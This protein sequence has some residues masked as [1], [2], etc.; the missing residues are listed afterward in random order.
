VER[1]VAL[2]IAT[3][4]DRDARASQRGPPTA[5][6]VRQAREAAG[7]RRDNRAP[8][9]ASKGVGRAERSSLGQPAH[10]PQMPPPPSEGNGK[11]AACPGALSP[12]KA[13]SGDG[14]VSP[15]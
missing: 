1:A 5:A 4:H 11:G 6:R 9:K 2:R 3:V 13:R 14:P 10:A 12:L 8:K 15:A 7:R